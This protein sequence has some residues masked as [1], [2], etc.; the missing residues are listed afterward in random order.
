MGRI[1]TRGSLSAA[2]ARLGRSPTST[3][4]SRCT[5]S[6]R[7]SGGEV[8][9]LAAEQRRH[10]AGVVGDQP[11]RDHDAVR[12][13]QLDRV[14]GE[15]VAGDAGDAGGQQRGVPL[16]DGADRALV[17]EQPAAR[18]AGVAQPELAGAGTAARRAR[19]ACR[20]ARPPARRRPAR[21][22]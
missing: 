5:T 21:S 12:P 17:E 19:T 7:Y 18:A 22:R 2:A 4:S 8:A 3:I 9:G 1:V 11:A 16:A 15:E 14:V 10:L 13:D 6:R 20:P